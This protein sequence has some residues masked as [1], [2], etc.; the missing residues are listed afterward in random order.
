MLRSACLIRV[1]LEAMM[2][3]ISFKILRPILMLEVL[4]RLIVLGPII[5]LEVLHILTVLRSVYLMR[6]IFYMRKKLQMNHL[7]LNVLLRCW[8]T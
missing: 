8:R 1:R 3:Q 7:N 2:R 4:H 6:V 5:I